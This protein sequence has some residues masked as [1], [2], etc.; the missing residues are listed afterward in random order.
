MRRSEY[1]FMVRRAKKTEGYNIIYILCPL[2]FDHY[3]YSGRSPIIIILLL[4][5]SLMVSPGLSSVAR[6]MYIGGLAA[7][8]CVDGDPRGSQFD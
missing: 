5:S 2:S 1:G 7:V 8:R 6:R 4:S 3:Y